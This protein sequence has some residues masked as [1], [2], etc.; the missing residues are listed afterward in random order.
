MPPLEPLCVRARVPGTV[1]ELRAASGS[2]VQA[3]EWVATLAL[4]TPLPDP[5][6]LRQALQERERVLGTA[7]T[8]YLEIKQRTE[9][10][11]SGTAQL[12]AA[13][14]AFETAEVDRN[15]ALTDL[16]TAQQTR[17]QL[18]HYAPCAG[19]VVGPAA[20]VGDVVRPGTPLLYIQPDP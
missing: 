10:G 5:A 11:R 14:Q 1:E 18:R 4:P 19:R 16:E 20:A 17:E 2:R 8:D 15:Q 6:R 13:R 7:R 9:T 12:A 3:G